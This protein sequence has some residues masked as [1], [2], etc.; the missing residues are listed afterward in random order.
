MSSAKIFEEYR[1][2]SQIPRMELAYL[3]IRGKDRFEKYENM[4]KKVIE[5][6]ENNDPR[7][8]EM[9]R[10]RM[11]E[12]MQFKSSLVYRNVHIDNIQTN[13]LYETAT[14]PNLQWRGSVGAVMVIQVIMA[15]GTEEQKALFLPNIDKFIWTT[16]YV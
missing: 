15:M 9:S 14:T 12:E 7:V 5:Q 11:H 2:R 3:V 4:Q 13:Y 10:E 8:F 16:A 6:I 1:K